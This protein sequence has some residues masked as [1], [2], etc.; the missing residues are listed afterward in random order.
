M[1]PDCRNLLENNLRLS[2]SFVWELQCSFYE[3]LGIDA[4]LS[5]VIPSQVT[6]NSFIAR[7]YAR[8]IASYIEDLGLEQVTILE[9]GAGH[10]RFGFLCAQHLGEILESREPRKT[11]WQYILSDV[12]VRNVQYWMNHSAFQGLKESQRIDF[13]RFDVNK[14]N[15]IRLMRSGKS[16]SVESPC[17]N[18]ILI[19]NYF[20]DSLPID[21][22][23]VEDGELYE[24]RPTFWSKPNATC[25]DKSE[26]AILEQVDVSWER[27]HVEKPVYANPDWNQIVEYHRTEVKNGTFTLPIKTFEL[28]DKLDSWSRNGFLLLSADKGYLRPTDLQDRTFPTMVQHG[29][30]S[31][32]VNFGAICKWIECRG[33]TP[34]IPNALNHFLEFAAFTSHPESQISRLRFEF[35]EHAARFTPADCHQLLR[36]C[37]RNAD[38][39]NLEFCLS[40]I[41]LSCYE[42]GVFYQLRHALRDFVSQASRSEY[43]A[44]RDTL[45]RVTANF[46]ALGNEDI[47]FEIGR[48][49]QRMDDFDDAIDAYHES[50]IHFGEHPVTSYNLALC[51]GEKNEF[52]CAIHHARRAIELAPN[53]SD[54]T[55]LLKSLIEASQKERTE[56]STDPK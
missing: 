35:N 50:I 19:A 10:G 56:T 27:Y 41:R 7:S 1:P 12:A 18:L 53:D 24:C 51:Y 34:L 3:S 33:G 22:W 45:K 47:L 9:L 55:K 20:F 13:A 26:F 5:G 36:R 11:E 29:C 49:Y 15:S 21:V 25:F 52:D 32:S 28:L 6:T 42:T 31:F 23:Q 43:A 4:W 30:F 54:S 46:F 44:V 14:E 37:G 17:E 2:Q 48:V 16:L 40:A 8:L 38:N 39:Q